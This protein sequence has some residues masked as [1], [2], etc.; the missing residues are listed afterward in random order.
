MKLTFSDASEWNP[1]VR[2]F[3]CSMLCALAAVAVLNY[4]VNPDGTYRS[5]VV[6]QLLWGARGQKLSLLATANPAPQALI[7]G[8]SRIMNLAPTDLQKATGLVAFNAGV[9]VARP[10]DFYVLLRYAVERLHLHPRLIVIG[11]D[12]EAFHNHEP[13]HYYLQQPTELT[14]YLWTQPNPHW[15]WAK[16]T[17]LFTYDETRSSLTALYKVT[18]GHADQ[19]ERTDSDGLTHCDGWSRQMADGNRELGESIRDTISRFAPRYDDYT[20]LSRERLDYLR[21]TLDFAHQSGSQTVIFLTPTH[22]LVEAGLQPHGYASRKAEVIAAV[23]SISDQT[24]TP[25]YDFSS[26]REF[27]GEIT[28]FIDGVHH[29]GTYFELMEARMFPARARAI[30]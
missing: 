20:A 15:R 3:L 27:G 10:E 25:F 13:P 9:D 12:V 4:V 29:D 24:K 18:T 2:T 5:R 1:F 19:L 21:A 7:L 30:Q 17:K 26:P 6:P 8:S 14:P 28:H 11:V 23:Q 22:P 16:F